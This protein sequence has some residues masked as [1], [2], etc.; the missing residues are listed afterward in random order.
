MSTPSFTL[1]TSFEDAL[2]EILRLRKVERAAAEWLRDFQEWN[3]DAHQ[4]AQKL[5]DL[6]VIVPTEEP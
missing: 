2:D 6:G 4:L 5:T 1:P 3:D